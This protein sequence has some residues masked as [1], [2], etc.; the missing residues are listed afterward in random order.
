MASRLPIVAFLLKLGDSLFQLEP[1]GLQFGR[2]RRRRVGA[3][4][5]LGDFGPQ[6]LDDRHQ[7]S[8]PL[9]ND[10]RLRSLG[11]AARGR[12]GGRSH[13][14]AAIV[15]ARCVLD[16]SLG[17]EDVELD[18]SD[19]KPI[20]GLEQRVAKRQSIETGVAGPT[21]NRG[22]ARAAQD[23]AVQRTNAGSAEPERASLARPDRALGRREPDDLA[24]PLRAHDAQV[25]ISDGTALGQTRPLLPSDYDHGKPRMVCC[26]LADF[27][28]EKVRCERRNTHRRFRLRGNMG[29]IR[30][31]HVAIAARGVLTICQKRLYLLAGCADYPIATNDPWPLG[32][33]DE[34]PAESTTRAEGAGSPG[35]GASGK[36]ESVRRRHARL[37][38]VDVSINVR[39][40]LTFWRGT[41]QCFAA[42]TGA[43]RKFGKNCDPSPA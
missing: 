13:D 34:S 21:A 16:H 41:K 17:R 18:G 43:G 35:S 31:F 11:L 38:V 8:R 14:R 3:R 37:G 19:R 26:D 9:A 28:R 1:A 5:K 42:H 39:Q 4:L 10:V 24:L 22:A 6:L 33:W 15:L 25:Q 12:L 20:A 29:Q 40:L 36:R 27:E 7:L 23:D 32:L 2:L 30:G